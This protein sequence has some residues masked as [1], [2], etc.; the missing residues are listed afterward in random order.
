MSTFHDKVIYQ[1]YPKSFKDTSSNGIGD[2]NG[3]K[4]KLPY[5]ADL[6]IDMLW[7]N[8]FYKS[9][10]NDNGYDV[11]DYTSIDPIFGTWDD[12][13]GLI[14]E[15]KSYGIDLMLDMVLNHTSTE[16]EWF[17]KAL[18]GDKKYQD[19]YILRELQEDGSL[20]TNWE[21]K[22]GGK[23]WS[24]FGDTDKY[25]LHLYDVTQADLNWRNPEVREELYKVVNFWLE[26]GVKGF[27]FDVIN[28]IGKDEILEDAEDGVGKSH[29]TDTPIVH[30]YIQELNKETFGKY[31]DIVTVGEMSSTT[32]ENGVKYS[33][34]ERNELSMIFS[35]HHLKVD[36]KDGEKW[37]IMP[38]DFIELKKILHE[39]QEGMVEGGGW[40]ALFWNNHDQPRANSRF[41]DVENYPVETSTMLA[42]TVHLLRGTPYIYQGE[43]IGMTNPNYEDLDEYVDIETH[44][45][46][47]KMQED[48]ISHD[49]AMAI[50][51]EKSRDNSRTPMQWN[52]SKNAGFSDAEPWLKVADNYKDINTE[53]TD[54][55]QAIRDYY[56]KLI[57]L[58]K[59]MPIISE[60]SYDV[61]ELEHPSIFAYV[62]EYEGEKLLVLNHFYAEDDK[63]TIPD[64]LLN[65]DASYLIGN[66]SERKLDKEFKLGPYETAAFLLK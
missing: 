31:E 43:E 15:A 29:Y 6:G 46:Y 61:L 5:L 36:Y 40:N 28:V 62:R 55:S 22:F 12:F 13:D 60:G 63:I 18:A 11:A 4:E 65:L 49:E 58:R 34:P 8:P 56:K 25:Y 35:F 59:D 41:G 39:W 24:K 44:N 53:N 26:K 20:P 64:E 2:L 23:A 45:A 10:Q 7:L 19:Y 38:F 33:N 48:G 30:D 17:Q 37:S 16:H 47:K 9:P 54:V 66:C 50:I 1:A 57:R 27:R 32:V 3:I 14:S 42:Q 51:K 21:S 52:D